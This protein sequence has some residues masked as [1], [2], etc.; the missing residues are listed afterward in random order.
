VSKFPGLQCEFCLAEAIAILDA[1][2]QRKQF[3][4]L[5]MHHHIPLCPTH[6]AR[7]DLEVP[8]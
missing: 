3:K 4:G 7:F 6:G 1:Y 2:E 5:D 8:A